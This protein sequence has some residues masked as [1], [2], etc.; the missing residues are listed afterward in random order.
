MEDLCEQRKP[1]DGAESEHP[2]GKEVAVGHCGEHRRVHAEYDEDERAADPWQD[3]GADGNRTGGEE[4]PQRRF[5]DLGCGVRRRALGQTEQEKDGDTGAEH[6][7]KA[8]RVTDGEQLPGD[9]R[10]PGD[11]PKEQGRH[12]LGI[13][14]EESLQGRSQRGDGDQDAG[15]ERQDELPLHLAQPG[16]G[17]IEI[18]PNQAS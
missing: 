14:V 3:H 17:L 4:R 11:Q 8:F 9:Q 2:E 15:P 1:D 12:H 5:P 13:V 7:R 6:D 16:F 10:G 18:K